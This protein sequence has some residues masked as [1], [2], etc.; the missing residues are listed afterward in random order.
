MYVC[1]YD[2]TDSQDLSPAETTAFYL[3]AENP[4]DK[5]AR[6]NQRRVLKL[7][8]PLEDGVCVTSLRGRLLIHVWNIGAF[9]A[10]HA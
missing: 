2:F 3:A 9:P 4:Q 7:V 8:F 5:R 10:L 6:K 1:L